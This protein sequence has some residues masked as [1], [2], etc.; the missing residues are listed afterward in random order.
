MRLHHIAL[1]IKDIEKARL[2][3]EHLL[4]TTFTPV[5]RVESQ[6]VLVSFCNL[7]ACPPIKLVQAAGSQSPQFPIMPHPVKAFIEKHGEGMH[8]ISFETPHLQNEIKRLKTLGIRTIS[9]QPEMGAEG[10]V[11]FLNPG[12]CGG[13]LVE[14]YEASNNGIG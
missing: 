14:I 3:W 12:D 9:P 5:K 1:A 13:T 10:L 2:L 11:V 7:G 6:D 8:H 4:D